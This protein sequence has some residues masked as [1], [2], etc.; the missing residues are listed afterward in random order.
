DRERLKDAAEQ[1]LSSEGWQRWVRARARNGLARYSVSNLCLI[2]HAKPD[3]SFVAGFKAWLALGYCVRKGERAIG[4]FAPMTIKDRDAVTG[5]DTGEKRTLFRVVSVFD[6]SQV[7]PIEGAQQAPLAPPSEPLSGDSH[8]DLLQPV[9]V[10]AR[11]LGYT[12]SLEQTP[13]GVGGWCDRRAKRIVVDADLPG[14]AQLR[15]LIHETTHAL[16]VDYERYSRAQAEVIVDTVTFIACSS[17][18]FVVDGETIPYVAG[19]GEDGALEAVGEFA[20]TIDTLAR[21]IEETLRPAVET[22]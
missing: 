4:I 18:G 3:A 20:K 9:G 6:E 17:V 1:L 16:G 14:N 19:W 21:R 12:V 2:L 5:E 13:S 7:A 22:A 15:T 10:L 11:S 8:A